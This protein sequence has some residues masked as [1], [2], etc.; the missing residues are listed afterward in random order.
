MKSNTGPYCTMA[1]D[2]GS[3]RGKR[4]GRHGLLK[5]MLSVVQCEARSLNADMA[6]STTGVG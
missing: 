4:E 1:L 6:A 5:S 3:L 2:H